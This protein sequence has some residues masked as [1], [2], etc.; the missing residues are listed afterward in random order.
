VLTERRYDAFGR[1]LRGRPCAGPPSLFSS[2]LGAHSVAGWYIYIEGI[3]ALRF[4]GFKETLVETNDSR[5][6]DTHQVQFVTSSDYTEEI[7]KTRMAIV[8]LA[9][10]MNIHF[11]F[12]LIHECYA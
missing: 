6:Q 4:Y 1:G 2:H 12:L 8:W 7:R 5:H 11:S 9:M 10:P 3:P